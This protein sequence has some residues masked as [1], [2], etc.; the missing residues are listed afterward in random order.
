MRRWLW[1]MLLSLVVAAVTYQWLIAA[2]PSILMRIVVHEVE[3]EAGA[4]ALAASPLASGEVRN[5]PRPSPDLAYSVCA[6]DASEGAVLVE[7]PSLPSAYWSVSVY[8]ANTDVAYVR[9]NAQANGQPI[10]L[11]IAQRDQP[12]PAGY[13]PVRV[14][15]PRGVLLLRVLVPDRSAFA[16]IDAARRA[17]TCRV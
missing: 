13:E 14:D 12:V 2:L 9:N 10:R 11:A 7:V 4:N 17:A 15:G 3:Q 1:P 8:G 16:A 5:I 6:F